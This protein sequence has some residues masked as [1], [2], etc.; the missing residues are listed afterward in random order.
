MTVV[1]WH[2]AATYALL[3][4]GTLGVWLG[5]SENVVFPYPFALAM[6][7]AVCFWFVD[8]RGGQA[9]IWLSN[10]LGLV[11]L[12][13]FLWEFA[14]DPTAAVVAL[15]HLLALL[16]GAKF[17]RRK[18]DID[19]WQLYGL[20]V[21]QLAVACVINRNLNFGL[22]IVG[23]TLLA[24]ATLM[25]FQLR[26]QHEALA[27]RGCAEAA[28]GAGF[29]VQ[30]LGLAT[31]SLPLALAA[32]WA[33]PRSGPPSYFGALGTAAPLEQ[34][35]TGFSP[36]IRLDEMQPILEN[37]DVVLNVWP[38]GSDG[39]PANLPDD[40]LWRGQV[41]LNYR[42]GQWAIDEERSGEL[43]ESKRRE[44]V[45][46]DQMLL[47]V[48]QQILTGTTIFAPQ[49]LF[50][51]RAGNENDDLYVNKLDGRLRFKRT[52]PRD[53]RTPREPVQYSLIVGRGSGFVRNPIADRL[54]PSTYL[55]QARTVP[56]SL[57]RLK[58][59]AA[60]LVAGAAEG[61][62]AARINRMIAHFR[63]GGFTYTLDNAPVDHSLDPV[64]DFLFNRKSGH[65]E[66]YATSM[67]LL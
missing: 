41:F 11:I 38:T 60:T 45:K 6:V 55:S 53:V 36:T 51:A 18:Q 10:A 61:D 46:T 25:L 66:Y 39:K 3:F 56:N 43:I 29:I 9:P 7:A 35:S 58:E 67:A 27:A 65:C 62:V 49:P 52:G 23:Y 28:T 63:A 17:L 4:L 2:I 31:L 30:W 24:L 32:F 26:R 12:T 1:R 21:L 42:N 22:L 37:K 14:S 47:R 64:E 50:W 33:L 48:E 44:P 57:V 8:V 19:Y 34:L 15:A 54:P 20:N 40:L 13:F 5:E 16:Q 59:L